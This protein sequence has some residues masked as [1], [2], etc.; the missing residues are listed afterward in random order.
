MCFSSDMHIEEDTKPSTRDL[1]VIACVQIA[2]AA[3]TLLSAAVCARIDCSK[4]REPQRSLTRR[5]VS[6]APAIVTAAAVASAAPVPPP[7]DV[8]VEVEKG[9]RVAWLI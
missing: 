1:I 5:R 2:L 6:E 4:W 8:T 9:G 3:A 7:E